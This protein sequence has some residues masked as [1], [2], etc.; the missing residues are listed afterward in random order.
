MKFRLTIITLILVSRV[1]FGQDNTLENIDDTVKNYF[2]FDYAMFVNEANLQ[3]NQDYI[4]GSGSAIG[5]MYQRRIMTN[6][7]GSLFGN[8]GF[9]RT[10]IGHFSLVGSQSVKENVMANE[11]Y[12]LITCGFAESLNEKKYLLGHI[13]LEVLFITGFKPA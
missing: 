11:N 4:F 9:G 5:V 2:K 12:L 6:N 13:D 3:W 10:S 1:L 7:N 8:M